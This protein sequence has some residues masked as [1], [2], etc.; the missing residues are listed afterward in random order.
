MPDSTPPPP[1]CTRATSWQGTS[2]VANP[3]PEPEDD[4]PLLGFAPY[5][6]PAPRSNSV[7][8]DRQRRFIATLAA[9]GIVSQAARSIGKSMEALYKLRARPGAEGF[10]AA[11]DEAL[12]RGMQR[13]EDCALERA[14]KG[15]PTP[16]V[17]GGQLLGTWD[18]PD[19][20]LLRFML[21]HRRSGRY[22]V[23]NIRPGHPIYESIKAEVLAEAKATARLNEPDIE[24]VRQEILRKVEAMERHDRA[25]TRRRHEAEVAEEH[26]AWLAE[27]R[28]APSMPAGNWS[29]EPERWQEPRE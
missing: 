25:I 15:T 28:A 16:I 7:T 12:E 22:G 24:D 21:Q 10:A 13:L 5:L 18:K 23:Q 8:P 27:G 6:H 2:A 9:T 11:W 19:N 29:E 3:G 1:A 4:D 17:S 14:L 20:G 26:A